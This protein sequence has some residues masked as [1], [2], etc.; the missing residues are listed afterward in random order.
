MEV[1]RILCAI[2]IFNCLALAAP[3]VVE[4][5][6]HDG[7]PV[8]AEHEGHTYPVFRPAT[9]GKLVAAIDHVFVTSFAAEMEKLFTLSRTIASARNRQQHAA[10]PPEFATPLYLLLSQEEGG[11]ARRDFFLQDSAGKLTFIPADYIDLQVDSDSVASGEF[12]EIFSHELGHTILHNLVGDLPGSRSN[13]MHQ[14]MTL[15]DYRTAFDEGF[16]EHFQ[17]IVREYSTN[18]QLQQ[19]AHGAGSQQLSAEFFNRRDGELRNFGPK[20]NLFV[21]D[22][23]VPPC[24]SV[25]ECFVLEETSASFNTYQLRTGQQMLSSEGF[26]ATVFYYAATRNDGSLCG[27]GNQL[28]CSALESRYRGIFEALAGV[29]PNGTQSPLIQFLESY[30]TRFPEEAKQF[31]AGFILLSRGATVSVE[32][33]RATRN[34]EEASSH[35]ELEPYVK[36]QHALQALLQKATDDVLAGRIQMDATIGPE[37]WIRNEAFTNP[38][39]WA[40]DEPSPLRINLN[41]ASAEELA[42]LPQFTSED[43]RN[44]VRERTQRGSFASINDFAAAVHLTAAQIDVLRK[45]EQSQLSAKPDPVR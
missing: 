34:L 14:S 40:S 11:Y 2:L 43:A 16:A 35:A 30:R 7:K 26:V 41:T 36:Q 37:L 8:T 29:K 12:E 28:D 18:P 42:T 33:L 22:R 44:L 4:P 21:Y 10:D 23:L 38:S 6:T 5:V 19:F 32:A 45:A 25:R 31:V 20:M 3:S 9:D 13:K 1:F 17:P 39:L 24:S 15:T 27:N